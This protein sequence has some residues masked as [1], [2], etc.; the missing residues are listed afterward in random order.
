MENQPDRKALRKLETARAVQPNIP[1]KASKRKNIDQEDFQIHNAAIMGVM[2]TQARILKTWGN[3]WTQFQSISIHSGFTIRA[4]MKPAQRVKKTRTAYELS[5]RGTVI[6]QNA[7]SLIINLLAMSK[8]F[9][10]T[11]SLD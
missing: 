4:V 11:L 3:V 8:E 10:D 7:E 5:T 9:L 1:E 2:N 6:L